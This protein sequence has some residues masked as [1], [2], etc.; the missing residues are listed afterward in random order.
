MRQAAALGAHPASIAVE[1]RPRIAWI[2]AAKGVSIV[3][4]VFGH[5]FPPPLSGTVAILRMPL[6][7]FLAGYLF[8]PRPLSEFLWKRGNSLLVPYLVY[9]AGIGL[10]LLVF[11]VVAGKTALLHDPSLGRLIGGV[12]YGGQHAGR[13]FVAF[14][15]LT[16]LF[17]ALLLF[18]TILNVF[19][20]P[21]RH[22]VVVLVM[23]G[24]ALAYALAG[25]H[26]PL[27][28]GVAPAA[29][30]FVWAGASYKSIAVPW[31]G[32][33]LAAV[34]VVLALWAGTPFIMRNAELR[35]AGADL[36]CGRRRVP[37]RGSRLPGTRR[38]PL[39]RRRLHPARQGVAGDHAAAPE[40]PPAAE[41][42]ASPV[43][44][45]DL[46]AGD[47]R[48]VP[49]VPA[50]PPRRSDWTVAAARPAAGARRGRRSRSGPARVARHPA[51]RG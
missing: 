1:P 28:I 50:V 23:L 46:P 9:M 44:G 12:L 4:V 37:P 45:R 35:R 42:H 26:T 20:S 13:Y 48:A 2:D 33:A 41:G 15:F 14:W 29:L 8:K 25:T 31:W 49:S 40:R 11:A 43:A 22:E 19:G 24:V 38:P 21:L 27:A 3:L 39:V 5:V 17:F 6:F 32:G 47:R 34:L 18:N 7:F 30:L 10:A 16:T 51:K 36:R